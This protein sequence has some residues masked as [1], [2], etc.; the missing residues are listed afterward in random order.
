MSADEEL[1]H[2]DGDA[3]QEYASDVDDDEG[4]ST[5]LASLDGETPDVAKPYG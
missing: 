1:A 2:H 4:G 3:Q 5:I